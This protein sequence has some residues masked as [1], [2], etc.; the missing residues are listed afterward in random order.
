MAKA[1][2]FRY[3]HS[4]VSTPAST[5]VVSVFADLSGVLKAVRPGGD[6]ITV[7]QVFENIL[8]GN[9]AG[10]IGTFATGLQPGVTGSLGSTKT[11]FI[12]TGPS[13]GNFAIPAYAV[14]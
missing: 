12:V 9:F 4:A 3:N 11:F 6:V 1:K 8:S 5:G 2:E 7:G 10:Q 14:S 13:G